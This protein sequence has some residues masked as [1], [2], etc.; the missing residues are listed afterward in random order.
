MNIDSGD[1]NIISKIALGSAQFG[2]DYGISNTSGMVQIDEVKKIIEY[3]SLFGINTIDTAYA[4]GKSEYIL[5]KIDIDSWNVISKLPSKKQ[6]SIGVTSGINESLKRLGLE[7]LYGYLVHDIEDLFLDESLWDKL[8][9]LKAK[10]IVK[11]IGVSVYKPEEIKKLMTNGIIPDIVQIPFN[12]LDNRFEPLCK[13]LRKKDCEIHSRS[14]FLQGLFF[15]P[16]KKIDSYF[17]P[18]KPFLD[19]L[20]RKYPD[21]EKRAGILLSYVLNKRNIDK[22]VIGI[23]SKNQLMTNIKF[24]QQGKIDEEI[25]T[26]ADKNEFDQSILMPNNWP[27]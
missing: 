7:N 5:G 21:K 16:I 13:E 19:L 26:W 12:I 18:I 15:C 3:A 8:T 27:S 24:A 17:D 10:N 4:Y 22:V 23:E 1:N 25:K 9:S 14:T 11:K 2:L 6:R 20:V